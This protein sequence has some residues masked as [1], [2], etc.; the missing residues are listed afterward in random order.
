MSLICLCFLPA[1]AA[2]QEVPTWKWKVDPS[3]P[4]PLP[5]HWMVGHM[6]RPVVDKDGNIWV[7]NY[8]ATL[9]RSVDHALFGLAQ[10]PP[11]SECCIPAPGVIEFDPEGN[12]LRAWGGAGYI[13][14]WPEA[15]HAFYVDKNMNV[16]LGG[17]HAP[18]RNVLKFSEDGKLLLEIGHLDGPIGVDYSSRGELAKPNNQDTDL[19]GGPS[20]IFVDEK[21][22]EVYIADGFINKRVVVYDSNTGKFKRG[23]GA[24]GIPLSMIDNNKVVP[25]DSFNPN[26]PLPKQFSWPLEDLKVSNDGLVYVADSGARR[27][28]VFTKEGTFVQE[29]TGQV[30]GVPP[31]RIGCFAFSHDPEQKY[32]LVSDFTNF[33]I[34]VLDR[35]TG[36]Q[37]ARFGNWGRNAG[38]FGPNL[39]GVVL[40]S[41][42]NLYTTET[43]HAFRLQK[44]LPEG[45]VVS[46]SFY[47]AQATA[48]EVPRYKVD[49]P[50]PESLPFTWDLGMIN[51]L[52]LGPDDNIWVLQDPRPLSKGELGADQKPPLSDCCIAAP[53]VLEF[54]QNGK[55]LRAWNGRGQIS[56]WPV[57]AHGIGVDKKGDV[58]IA[59]VGKPWHP[60]LPGFTMAWDSK[61][62]PI[63][64]EMSRKM[65]DRQVLKFT[66]DGKLLLEIGQPSFASE[67][68]Q[69][70]SILGAPT[71]MAFDDAAN[72]V[73]IADGL[74]NKRIVVYDMNTGEF[75]RGWG[76]Y[77]IPLSKIDNSNPEEALPTWQVRNASIS[78]P[79]QFRTVTGIAFSN[80][81]IVYV[82]DQM[83]NRIQAFTKQGKFVK[84]MFVAPK[85][86]GNGSAWS[87][88]ISRDPKQRFLF[89][90]DG[91]SGVIRILDRQTG[92]DLGTLGSKGRN[93]G[94]FSNPAF[95]AVDSHGT[96]YTG[97]VNF[98]REWTGTPSVLAGTPATSGGR[99]QRFFQEK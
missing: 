12:V 61:G 35:R 81:E 85:T 87:L 58:W 21:A 82:T 30:M 73:Y 98:P 76:A 27:I 48:Q 8:A 24:Y 72:E 79:K 19:L 31:F 4:K 9:D 94:Q 92:T 88:A 90:A 29:F 53:E 66:P 50:W 33:Y 89:V 38:Q 46:S 77:G 51:G 71:A 11:I 28:Q 91:M 93:A 97:E 7:A 63:P 47:P 84:E 67:N 55:V 56:T 60:D 65:I 3:W 64:E 68:N 10:T 41:M 37:V 39:I 6:E 15:L 44:F 78:P 34:R 2:A 83:N 40:D 32:L 74:M 23:W 52:A 16:W 80:D 96:L 20:G 5:N 86:G 26:L 59:G 62:N 95:A 25:S 70:T 36:A 13:P 99:L 69:D 54:D 14:Q 43:T 49:A 17:N 22:N 45:S 42:G 75:K 1:L 18:D 57:A